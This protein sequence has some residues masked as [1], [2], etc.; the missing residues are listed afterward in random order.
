MKYDI[1][2]LTKIDATVSTEFNCPVCKNPL[3]FRGLDGGIKIWCPNP[4]SV[5]PSIGTNEGGFGKKEADAFKVLTEK[6]SF[7]NK[8]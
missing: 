4:M 5:C 8:R 6:L 7:G 1:E 2:E 3:V